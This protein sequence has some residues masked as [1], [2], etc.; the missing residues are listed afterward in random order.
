MALHVGRTSLVVVICFAATRAAFVP[1][2]LRRA[3]GNRIT[4]HQNNKLAVNE[5]HTYPIYTLTDGHEIPAIGFGT[6]RIP[7]GQNTYDAVRMALQQGYRMIDTAA[8]YKN[9]ADVGRA[10]R[11]SG[12]PR[13]EIVVSTKIFDFDHGFKAAYAA[14]K[15]CNER[16]GLGHIDVLLIHSPNFGRI[17]E[18]YDALLKLQ[19]EGVVRSVGV[20]NFGVSHLEALARYCRPT[21]AINQF[22]LHPMNIDEPAVAALVKYCK[23]NNILV[24][25]YGSILSGHQDL[26][27]MATNTAHTHKKSVAQ[28]MLRWALDQGFQVL[29]KSVHKDRIAE[30]FD[31]FDFALSHSEVTEL[32]SLKGALVGE[33]WKPI[34]SMVGVGNVGWAP[35]SCPT[36]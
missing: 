20:S 23:K 7:P 15:K 8:L 25:A 28:V 6:Y 14:G 13:S 18:T 9:E 21:P 32:S 3:A 22:E 17:V 12:I 4:L 24:Q 5:P 34:T 27:N 35:A 10:I 1:A 11:D 33:Y 16:L 29:P 2:T 31:L 36:K 26:L 30:N 19:K